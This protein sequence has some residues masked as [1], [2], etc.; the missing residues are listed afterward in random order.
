[1]AQ[2]FVLVET[3]LLIVVAAAMVNVKKLG[4]WFDGVAIII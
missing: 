3:S 2:W 4:L 1:M